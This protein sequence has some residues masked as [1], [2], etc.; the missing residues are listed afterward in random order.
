MNQYLEK[1]RNIAIIAHVD[2]G[3]TTLAKELIKEALSKELAKE[4]NSNINEVLNKI[5]DNNAQESERG[6]TILSKVT[7][8]FWKENKIVI[9]DTP[10]HSDFGAEVERVL[11]MVDTVLL[12][13]DSFEGPM[14]QTKFVLSK[15]L[16]QGLKVIVV[17]NKIDKAESRPNE[18]INEIFD[19]FVSLGA[20][21][22]QLDFPIVYASA[23][24]GWA[25]LDLKDIKSENKSMSVLLDTIIEK[26]SKPKCLERDS[27]SMLVT[28]LDSNPYF[29]RILIGKIYSGS[30]KVGS[31]IQALD[32]NGQVLETGKVTKIFFNKGLT[33]VDLEVARAGDIV[34][35]AGL[36]NATVS[37][38]ISSVDA[39]FIIPTTPID[40]P[41]ISM[42]FSVNDSPFCGKSGKKLTSRMI[43]DWLNKEAETNVSIKI[44][45]SEDGNYYEVSGRGELQLGILIENMR[46]EGFELSVGRPKVIFKTSETGE[47]LEPIE[48]VI[49]DVDTVYSGIVIEKLSYRKGELSNMD[50]MPGD[51]TRLTFLCPSRGLIGYRNEFLTDTRGTGIL[52]K[53]FHSYVP[54]KGHIEGRKNGVLISNGTGQSTAYDL[55][56]M[57]ERGILFIGAGEQVYEGQI[58]GQHNRDNDLRV[59]VIKGKK[60]TNMRSKSSDGTV[61][62]SPPKIMKLE[63][64]ISYINEDELI[65][66]TPDSIRL[67]KISLLK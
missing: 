23:K 42:S 60:L 57:E 26:V 59:N 61:Q 5:L 1:I 16:N 36:Q 14:P 47:K 53:S 63:D 41:T 44:K 4:H 13:V 32:L 10:G 45:I 35:I 12:L 18:V 27:F 46:R 3:K 22:E 2:H 8:I 30:I 31:P 58:I 7:T 28:N 66:V 34:S 37:N 38:T 19:L 39:K 54:Y 48:E 40:P 62:L 6:I 49:I 52:N 55:A 33:P 11:S 43:Y 17:I 29:G 9:V 51:K 65:E 25:V 64:S 21:D 56:D 20:S 15:A 67:R 50:S 24:Q